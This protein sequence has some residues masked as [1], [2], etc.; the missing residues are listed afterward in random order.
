MR[1]LMPIP[2]SHKK[3]RLHSA[4]IRAVVS[5]AE[6][7]FAGKESDYGIDGIITRVIKIPYNDKDG[8]IKY[9]YLDGVDLF[10]Y[11]LKATTKCERDGNENVK[12]SL[13]PTFR[14]KNVRKNQL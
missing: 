6:H 3:E 7:S 12:Y 11:Q 2:E 4:Y 10:H 9:K 5:H 13:D 8:S 14:S 1:V